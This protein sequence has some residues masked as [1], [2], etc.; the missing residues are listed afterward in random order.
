VVKDKQED[1]CFNVEKERLVANY[2]IECLFKE[3]KRKL[4]QTV[5][6]EIGHALGKG[7]K[8]LDCGCGCMLTPCKKRAAM[9]EMYTKKLAHDM[10]PKME[11]ELVKDLSEAMLQS[12]RS[13]LWLSNELASVMHENTILKARIA[14]V[15]SIF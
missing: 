7:D 14:V 2:V 6:E 8:E 9:R 13:N 5:D 11:Q 15:A 3:K 1:K 4:A 10:W 12:R